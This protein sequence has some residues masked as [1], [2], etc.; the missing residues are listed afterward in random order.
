M[1][2]TE[3]SDW[4]VA[5]WAG[6]PL[7]MRPGPDDPLGAAREFLAEMHDS[8][9]RPTLLHWRG[10]FLAWDGSC[11]R[12]L[13]EQALKAQ[14]Y[15]FFE[16]AE[17]RDERAK[18]GVPWR[19]NKVKVANLVDAVKAARHLP[20]DVEERSSLSSGTQWHAVQP[21]ARDA[22]IALEKGLLHIPSRTIHDAT[23]DYFTRSHARV[24]HSAALG[25]TACHRVPDRQPTA[26]EQ[27]LAGLWPNDPDAI[28]LLQ[29]WFGYVLSGD[30][31]QQKAM[32]IVGPPRSGKG[33][34]G[35][36]LQALLGEGESAAPTLSSMA[37]NFGLSSLIGKS[38][39]IVSDARFG[40]QHGD[41]VVERLLSITGEDLQDVD[42]K[43]LPV[44]TGRL[45]CRFMLMT[46]EL[47]RLTDS[48]GALA[49]RFLM[50]ETS[51]SWLGRE[52]LGLEDRILAD[53]AGIL[54]WALDGLD[55]LRERGRFTEPASSQEIAGE[56]AELSSPIKAFI[57]ARCV[58]GAEHEVPASDLFA[59]WS[60][61][62]T[63]QGRNRPGTA[64]VFGRDLRAAAPRVRIAQPR[65]GDSR[66]RVYQGIDCRCHCPNGAYGEHRDTCPQRDAA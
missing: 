20:R 55:R 8:G 49:S 44:W 56:M 25:W 54:W 38:L 4:G 6:E 29:E 40:G 57:K 30:T 14:L 3:L 47:P 28:A 13:D 45:G 62:C 22:W 1:T 60:E 7:T 65:V 63:E 35:R 17:Y 46:N 15:G 34:I 58:V 61:W 26:W 23:P 11:W 53:P 64:Q 51:T 24:S 27:F 52:D 5:E 32:L 59:A 48:S 21:Y 50:L 42:R 18:A 16:G 2:V 66:V 12:A 41:V 19:P 43:H 39:A 10:E 37:S 36:V 33:T 9:G 31:R